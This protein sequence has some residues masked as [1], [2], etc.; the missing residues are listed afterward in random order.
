VR[1]GWLVAVGCQQGEHA[2]PVG[3]FFLGAGGHGQGGGGGRG[4]GGDG[5]GEWGDKPT[6]NPAFEEY[7]QGQ[8]IV[9]EGARLPRPR[10]A[11]RRPASA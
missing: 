3:G 8:G 9:P 10:P 2:A 11:A 4:G 7:Y 5:G 1:A 6:G